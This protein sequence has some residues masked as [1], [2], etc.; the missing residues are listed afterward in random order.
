[1]SDRVW[2]VTIV[3]YGTRSTRRA[4]VFLN[5]HAYH[6]EDGPIDMDYFF[7]VLRSEEET[8][9][10][11]TGFSRIGGDRRRRTMLT[12][13]ADA[14]RLAGIE[15]GSA[16]RIIVTHG[17]FDH[18]GNLSVFPDADL[19]MSRKEYDFWNGPHADKALFAHSVEADELAH[20]RDA[21]ERGRVTFIEGEAHIAPGIRLLEIGGHT[22]GQCII[23]V[24]TSEG[25]VLLASDAVHYY[26]EYETDK[27]FTSVADLVEMYDSFALIRELVA[28]GEVDH[29]VSGHDPSTLGRF[30]PATGALEG[31]AATIGAAHPPAS[32]AHSDAQKE[33]AR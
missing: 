12:E 5:Y 18:I 32:G 15:P 33:S 27:I 4:E 13:P 20:L 29:V 19:T 16:P 26:E 25:T 22:P 6:Q 21:V 1:M 23:F 17:H 24:E 31:I 3:K 28:S 7:W 2:E 8:I 10:V 30:T 14:F 11:D 9:L